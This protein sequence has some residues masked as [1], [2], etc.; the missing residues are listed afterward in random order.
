MATVLIVDDD[1]PIRMLV[2]RILQRDGHHVISARHG[3]EAIE[4]LAGTNPDVML[5]DVMM[6]VSN[7][8]EVLAYMREQQRWTPTIILT[9]VH[10]RHFA[11]VDTAGVYAIVRKPFDLNDLRKTV[12]ACAGG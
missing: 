11:T 3:G 1:D 5:L 10:E 8:G 12:A 4:C 2:S 9:A 6:P 7:G